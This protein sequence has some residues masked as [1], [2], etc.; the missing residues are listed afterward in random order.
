MTIT[1]PDRTRTESIVSAHD[2]DWMVGDGE[3]GRCGCGLIVTSEDEWRRQ[4]EQLVVA[5]L[6]SPT[7]ELITSAS[8]LEG[9]PERS[10]IVV[11]PGTPTSWRRS[12]RWKTAWSGVGDGVHRM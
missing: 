11:H 10:V 4:T 6:W 2:C 12:R 5:E 3:Q 7:A 1:T 9:L 8:A